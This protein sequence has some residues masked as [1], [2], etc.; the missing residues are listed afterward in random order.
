MRSLTALL[1]VPERRSGLSGSRTSRSNWKPTAGKRCLRWPI[2]SRH[3]SD[4][5][6][7]E[8]AIGAGILE[9]ELPTMA[10]DMGALRL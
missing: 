8:R 9:L 5:A 7:I 2:R 1:P 3:Y 6:E 10:C 4:L